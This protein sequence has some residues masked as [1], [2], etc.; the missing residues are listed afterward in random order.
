MFFILFFVSDQIILIAEH[1][2]LML[3]LLLKISARN[4]IVPNLAHL[5][6]DSLMSVQIRI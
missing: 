2:M 4:Y 1:R 5:K 6:N 3:L